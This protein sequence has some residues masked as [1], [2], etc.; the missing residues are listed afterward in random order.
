MQRAIQWSK[1][2]FCGM[3][4]FLLCSCGMTG[5]G[6]KNILRALYVERI[7]TEYYV[8]LICFQSV[9]AA[10]TS[11]AHETVQLI[12]G[13]GKTIFDALEDAENSRGEETFYG[14]NELLLIGPNLAEEGPFEATD[15]M[16]KQESGR[17]NTEVYVVNLPLAELQ[18]SSEQLSGL[19]DSIELLRDQGA[20][21]CALY[22]LAGMQNALVPILHLDTQ[23]VSTVQSG[24]VLYQDG[25]PVVHWDAQQ[26]QLAQLLMGQA[27]Q[28]SF[29]AKMDQDITFQVDSTGVT[30]TVEETKSG[31]ILHVTLR[32]HIRQIH[33]EQGAQPPQNDAVFMVKLNQWMET[34]GKELIAESFEKKNDVFLFSSRLKNYNAKKVEQLEV[35]GALYQSKRVIFHSAMSTL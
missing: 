4:L 33:T 25:L 28:M 27:Q 6:S 22:Q 12:E 8:E 11:E 3:L 31:P 7:G 10:D 23:A 1:L 17:P 32:G 9:P 14:Q 2:T 13:K 34:M 30:Y 16:V 21:H 15:F 35:Q 26:T 20:Y 18:N 5:I 24:A 19:V 29:E